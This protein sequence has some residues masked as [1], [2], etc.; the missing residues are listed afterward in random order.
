V[1]IREEHT[2]KVFESRVLGRIF[3]PTRD[4]TI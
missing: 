3:A 1:T 2:Q 4:E